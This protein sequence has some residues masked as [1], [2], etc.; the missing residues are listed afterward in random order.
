MIE[1]VQSL[2]SSIEIVGKLRELSKK[3]EDAD[4]KMFLADLSSELGDAKLEVANLKAE[5]ASLREDNAALRE[6]VERREAVRPTLDDSVYRFDGDDG[7]YCT[8]CFDVRQS[9]VRVRLLTGAFTAFGKWECPAC[10]TTFG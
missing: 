3:I 8:A 4:F 5:L 7:H 9:K 1:I 10:K 2:Q 6:R